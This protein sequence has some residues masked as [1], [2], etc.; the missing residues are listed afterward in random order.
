MDLLVENEVVI[1]IKTVD[2]LTQ[3]HFKQVRTYLKLSNNILGYLINFN[4]ELIM[5]GTNRI[6]MSVNKR[7]DML[8]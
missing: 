7:S 3:V 4:T 6:I 1:E 2:Q 8:A 5:D